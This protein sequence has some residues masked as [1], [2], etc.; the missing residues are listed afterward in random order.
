MP[1]EIIK[2]DITKLKTDAI[3]NAANEALKRGGG[4]CGAIF[5]AAGADEL[6]RECDKIGECKTGEAVITK[7]YNLPA[8]HIIHTVGP[9]W[10]GGGHGE[11]T[12]L[13]NCYRNSLLLAKKHNLESIAFPLISSGIF[14]YPKDE[15]MNVAETTINE[16][17]NENEMNVYLVLFG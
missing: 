2:G 3:V 7:G 14:G 4:V 12:L 9:V 6:Q 1:F 13:R 10:H 16:F 17:L 8:K 11:E 5:A 15:A